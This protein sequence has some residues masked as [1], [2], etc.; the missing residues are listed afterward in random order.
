MMFQIGDQVKL[1]NETG[2][3]IVK[4]INESAG[5]AMV[6]VDGFDFE[7]DLTDLVAGDGEFTRYQKKKPGFHQILEKDTTH[8]GQ[9]PKRESAQSQYADVL[10]NRVN[11]K[12]QPE[13]DLHIHEIA[14]NYSGMT[15]G[16]IVEYQMGYLHEAVRC[17]CNKKVR[18]LIVI[19]GVGEGVL[20]S[21]VRKY[22]ESL[23]FA[24][25]EDAPL[26]IY[27]Y[28]ATYVRLLGLTS[29]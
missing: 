20:K 25:Y 5:T 14:Q 3:G 24:R 7:Y 4:S 28:G 15:N 13:I 23:S 6:E 27:G 10:F 16:E 2:E 9:N 22:L 18:E 11:D 26:K 12:G 19:H 17:A 29:T 1:L 8:F 21:E